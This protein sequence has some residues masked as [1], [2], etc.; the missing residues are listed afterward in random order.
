LRL[1]ERRDVDEIFLIDISASRNNRAPRFSELSDLCSN[2]FCPVTIGGG[3]RSIGDFARMFENGADKVSIGTAALATPGLI[4]QASRKWG[5]QAVV[6]AVDVKCGK[7]WLR[8]GLSDSGKDPVSWAKECEDR[9]A[10]E[11]LLTSIERDG[12]MQGYNLD[13]IRSVADAVSIP[14]VAAGGCG[15]YEHMNQ[16]FKAG[17]HAVATGAMLQFTENTPKEAARYL[18]EHGIATRV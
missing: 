3:V 10:G 6:V 11:I 8:C 14:V 4:D 5:A 18:Q 17:A 9:G 12:M 15:N 1:L 7:V 2:L 13:L 16:A